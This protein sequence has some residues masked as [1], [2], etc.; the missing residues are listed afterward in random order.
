MQDNIIINIIVGFVTLIVGILVAW[1]LIRRSNRAKDGA[2]LSKAQ[3]I[4]REAEAEAEVI[5]KNKILEAK[6]KFLQLKSEHEK[7]ISEKDRNINAAEN[8]IKQ[9]EAA[10]SQKMEQ[11]QRKQQEYE[12]L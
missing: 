10:V 7:V 11:T 5:K 12:T 9:K 1:L 3:S 4:L 8:R 6:E 2:A